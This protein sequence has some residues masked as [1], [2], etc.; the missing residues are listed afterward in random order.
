[1]F[2]GRRS[3]TRWRDLSGNVVTSPLSIGMSLA[4]ALAAARGETAQEMARA[5]ESCSRRAGRAFEGQRRA[6]APLSPNRCVGSFPAAP[7][8]CAGLDPARRGRRRALQGPARVLFRGGSFCRRRGQV[9]PWVAQQT[10]GMIEKALGGLPTDDIAVLLN[11]IYF[12]APWA[13]PFDPALTHA[14]R[15]FCASSESRSKSK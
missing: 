5:L 6:C 4:M 14:G 12:K 9:N 7:C 1:M 15:F 3:S 10:E 13:K 2:W 11:A 8:Q